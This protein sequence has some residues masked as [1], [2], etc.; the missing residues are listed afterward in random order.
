MPVPYAGIQPMR[1]PQRLGLDRQGDVVPVNMHS[2]YPA[3]EHWSRDRPQ[4]YRPRDH[5]HTGPIRVC[6]RAGAD[7]VCP[8]LAGGTHA[9]VKRYPLMAKPCTPSTKYDCSSANRMII[10][11]VTI[12]AMAKD[13]G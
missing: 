7:G 2:P 3:A 11:S 9:R 12:T 5:E 1:E 8:G 10:G 13:A 6:T 4:R